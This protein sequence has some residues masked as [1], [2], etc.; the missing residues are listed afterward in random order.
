MCT[1]T[2]EPIE[3]L[4][5]EPIEEPQGPRDI[6]VL[7]SLETY[8]GMTDEEIELIIQWKQEHAI[9]NAEL[10]ARIA[11]ETERMEQTLHYN[12]QGC[13]RALDMI[14]SLLN[15][16]LPTYEPPTPPVVSPT[17]VTPTALEV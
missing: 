10:A 17:T 12:E 14:E 2:D 11:I 4:I 8:Q 3:E 6:R 13:Q 1:Q 15:R 5:E 9:V 7:L 16:G